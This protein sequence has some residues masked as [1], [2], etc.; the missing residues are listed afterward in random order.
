MISILVV[1]TIVATLYFVYPNASDAK[2]E[3]KRFLTHTGAVIQT[4]GDILD[5]V[6]TAQTVEFDPGKYLREFSY[7]RVSTL[8]DGRT[9]REFTIIANDDKI[10]EISPGVF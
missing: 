9:L 1:T 6:Y 4:T 2:N 8:E 3:E 5:P 7:G 10:M